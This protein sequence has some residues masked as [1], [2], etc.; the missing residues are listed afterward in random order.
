MTIMY[1][2]ITRRF[3]TNIPEHPQLDTV[4]STSQTNLTYSQ[5]PVF[6][7]RLKLTYWVSF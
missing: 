3:K 7:F 1:V 2:A 6:I 4:L 5:R